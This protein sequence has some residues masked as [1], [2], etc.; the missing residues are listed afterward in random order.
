MTT[1]KIKSRIFL[2]LG[3]VCSF[4]FA[5]IIGIDGALGWIT[6]GLAL[7]FF[8]LHWMQTSAWLNS[9]PD[10]SSQEDSDL[11]N[12]L[13]QVR[14]ERTE[15]K[16]QNEETQSYTGKEQSFQIFRKLLSG[17]GYFILAII[18]FVFGYAV[19][20]SPN[21]DETLLGFTEEQLISKGDNSYTLTDYDSAFL[22]YSVAKQKN[23]NN[24]YALLGLGNVKYTMGQ[25]D[26]ALWYYQKTIAQDARFSAGRY[27]V[28]WWHYAQKKYSEAISRLHS[29]VRDEPQNGQAL[30][31]LGDAYYDFKDFDNAFIWYNKA[32]EAKYNNGWLCYVL[33]YLYATRNQPDRAIALYKEALYFDP[34]NAGIYENLADLL[35]GKEGE[36]YRKKADELKKQVK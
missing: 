35:P 29:L 36:E 9:H 31:L 13:K 32:Y 28:A 14:V 22:Y 2:R 12:V 27:N 1:G 26:S 21:E 16:K 18:I 20:T 10:E 3:I 4:I 30:Q 25:Y 17:F 11:D 7:S 33:G 5:I 23:N 8:V 34:N 6:L 19:V 24:L 15:T